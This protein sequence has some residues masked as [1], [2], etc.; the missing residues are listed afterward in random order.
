[1][2]AI[3]AS[4][5][6]VDVPVEW[7]RLYQTRELPSHHGEPRSAWW[8]RVAEQSDDHIPLFYNRFGYSSLSVDERL[9][10]R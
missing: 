5:F 4:R 2:T 7:D 3:P 8:G 1:M 9:N 6:P 10:E